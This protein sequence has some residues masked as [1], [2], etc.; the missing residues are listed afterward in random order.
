MDIRV[1]KQTRIRIVAPP[2]ASLKSLAERAPQ[3]EALAQ[4][5]AEGVAQRLRPLLA[6]FFG[7]RRRVATIGVGVLTVWFL[8]HVM[9]GPNG[10]MV[11]QQ[12]KAE[13]QTLE[14]EV[15]SLQKENDRYSQQIKS[16]KS[17]PQTIEREAREQLH[18]ARPG[19]VVYVSPAPVNPQPPVTNSAH[20]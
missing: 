2:Q 4:R 13:Y 12:K 15:D 9:F 3:A 17:D 19:E 14:T 20:K 5:A 11:Y 8:F 18:Y 7:A 1:G 6:W 10:M 16:L